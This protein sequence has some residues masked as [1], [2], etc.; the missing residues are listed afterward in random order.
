MKAKILNQEGTK[1]I[2]LPKCFSSSIRKDICQKCYEIEKKYSPYAPYLLAGKQYSASGKIRHARRK[3]KTSYGKGISRV[4][5]KIFWRRGTQFYWQG[6]TVTQAVGGRRAHPPRVEHFFKKLKINKKEKLIA[7]NSA[8]ACTSSSEWLKKRY[9]SLKDKKLSL[10]LPLIISSSLLKLKTKDFF[11]FLKGILGDVYEI[12]I[13]K[14][15]VRAGKGKFRGRKYKESRGLLLVIG[16]SEEK[17]ISQID[18][19]KVSELAIED[20]YPLG[21]LVIYTENAIKD[22]EKLYGKEEK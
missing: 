2:E 20:L 21:R 10:D 22:L 3:W 8:L 11:S 16:N 7:I 9:S 13:K 18:V 4:P 6:A 14:K 19:K 15:K 1:E 5:R 12:A 17:K